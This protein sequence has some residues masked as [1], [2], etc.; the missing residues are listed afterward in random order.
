MRK[1]MRERFPSLAETVVR[2]LES[3]ETLRE[4]CEDL[5]ACESAAARLERPEGGSPELRMEYAALRLRLERELLRHLEESGA[6]TTDNA[7]ASAR[8]AKEG[9]GGVHRA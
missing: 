5:E 6:M 2:R 1:L 8:P 7:G 3:D 4:L 9:K